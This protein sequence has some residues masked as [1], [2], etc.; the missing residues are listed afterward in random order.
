MASGS[1]VGDRCQ[2]NSVREIRGRSERG[3]ATMTL[4]ECTQALVK[5][6]RLRQERG[7]SNDEEYLVSEL[8]HDAA[9]CPEL[10]DLTLS[11]KKNL[12]R[13]FYDVIKVLAASHI[14]FFPR[15]KKL[16]R[17]S[18][19]TIAGTRT[20]AQF[21]RAIFSSHRREAHT[22]P[23][24]WLSRQLHELITCVAERKLVCTY[25]FLF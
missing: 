14:V 7:E 25:L 20:A 11:E 5:H 1:S 23:H 9:G 21:S 18:K 12:Y 8:V 2:S 15:S 24:I 4:V 10:T 6:L 16:S 22:R 3:S 17:A 19:F 13:R